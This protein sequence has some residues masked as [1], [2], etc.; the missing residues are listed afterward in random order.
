MVTKKL[1]D[2]DKSESYRNFSN[3]RLNKPTIAMVII[4]GLLLGFGIYIL[5]LLLTPKIQKKTEQTILKSQTQQPI[6]SNKNELII[7][8]AGIEAE[9]S[10]G[11]ITVLDKG[12]VW[13][14]L[15]KEGNPTIGGNMILTGHSFVWGYTPKQVKEKSIFYNL[16][17]AKKG[18]LLQVRWDG[19]IYK[20]KVLE[21]KQVKPNATEIEKPSKEPKLTI[22]TCTLGGSADGRVVVIAIPSS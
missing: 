12:L 3:P 18:D 7:P 11:N 16:S 20:Y 19:K 10:E 4:A 13:H 1:T 15:P 17:D 14:R 5:I 6:D 22:Y 2:I 9:I 8:S 21:I